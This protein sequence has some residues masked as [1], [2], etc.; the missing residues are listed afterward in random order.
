M[1]YEIKFMSPLSGGG[2][3]KEKREN[4]L[5]ELADEIKAGK[6]PLVVTPNIF[7][8]QKTLRELFDLETTIVELPTPGYYRLIKK[9]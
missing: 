9:K 8:Y 3:G 5:K 2:Y 4:Q 7:R 6:Q 1:E